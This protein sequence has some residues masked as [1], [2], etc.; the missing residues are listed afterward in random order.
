MAKQGTAPPH[1]SPSA[2]IALSFAQALAKGDFDAAH[3]LVAPASRGGL[4]PVDLALHYQQMTS[5]W[6]APPDRI[7][8]LALDEQWPN[9]RAGDVAWAFVGIDSLACS[10]LEAINVRIVEEDGGSFIGEIVWGRF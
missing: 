4:S 3:M 7:E 9:K 8:L 10:A 6:T 5:D 1:D 2:Q